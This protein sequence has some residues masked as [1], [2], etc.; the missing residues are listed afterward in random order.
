M[1][2]EFML[3]ANDCFAMSAQG[4][5]RLAEYTLPSSGIYAFL[6]AEG[7]KKLMM[8]GKF[9]PTEVFVHGGATLS[10]LSDRDILALFADIAEQQDPKGPID[11]YISRGKPYAGPPLTRI[12]PCTHRVLADA[13]PVDGDAWKQLKATA[14]LK[15]MLLACGMP[16]LH[17]GGKFPVGA[18]F[19]STGVIHPALIGGDIGCG[20]SVSDIATYRIA[21][22]KCTLQLTCL[23]MS[24][25]YARKPDKL[26]DRLRLI[27]GPYPFKDASLRAAFL[28]E[29][30]VSHFLPGGMDA[31][32]NFADLGTIGRHV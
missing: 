9:A 3:I 27:E 21:L 6:A 13:T 25:K 5:R 18:V 26:A 29:H 23:P 20:M 4:L 16:D 2:S 17:A 30:G 8:K 19:I 1:A 31:S 14:G 10:N 15:G 12:V 7:R 32:P 24:V 11:L 28:T 22:L